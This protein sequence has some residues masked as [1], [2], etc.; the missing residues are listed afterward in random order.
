VSNPFYVIKLV[1][2]RDKATIGYF[3]QGCYI[4]KLR[5]TDATRFTDAAEAR[6]IALGLMPHHEFGQFMAGWKVRPEV[7]IVKVR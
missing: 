5:N 6:G 1:N 3:R 2:P 4:P 7:H